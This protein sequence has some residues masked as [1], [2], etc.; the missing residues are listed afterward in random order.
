MTKN[1][2]VVDRGTRTIV[3]MIIA[4]LIL[5]NVVSGTAAI[6]LGVVAALFLLTSYISVCPLY[7]LLKISTRKNAE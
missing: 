1:M 4:I 6:V 2:G 7:M 5:T 3:A